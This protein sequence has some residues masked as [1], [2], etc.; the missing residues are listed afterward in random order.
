MGK[1]NC[2]SENLQKIKDKVIEK[3]PE[4][5]LDVNVEWEGYSFFFSGDYVPVNPRI[6]IEY[7][8]AKKDGT[9]AKNLT[10]ESVG[11]LCKYCPFCGRELGQDSK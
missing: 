7:R 1:C 11:M 9:P 10:K 8:K 6:S 3:L 2:F 5:A 4:G